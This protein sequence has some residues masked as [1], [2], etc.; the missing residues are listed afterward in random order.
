MFRR[1]KPRK[2]VLQ[3][4]DEPVFRIDIAAKAQQVPRFDSE[5]ALHQAGFAI[6]P[7]G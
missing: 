4:A 5:A 1:S 7:Q 3:R 6:I 2:P